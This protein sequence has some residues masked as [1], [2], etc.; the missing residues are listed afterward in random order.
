MIDLVP[1]RGESPA[2]V[3]ARV[4]LLSCVSSDVMSQRSPLGEPTCALRIRARVWLDPQVY[5]PMA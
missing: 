5:I 3:P 4:G 1:V 2:A